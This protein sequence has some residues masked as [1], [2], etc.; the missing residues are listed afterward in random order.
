MTGSLTMGI[1]RRAAGGA[2]AGGVMGALCYLAG[3]D[4]GQRAAWALGGLI[5]DVAPAAASPE[6]PPP[7]VPD[8][9]AG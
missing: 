1:A 4:E 7:P 9:P 6:V 5:D 3:R 2:L 8:P